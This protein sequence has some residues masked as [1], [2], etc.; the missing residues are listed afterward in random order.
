MSGFFGAGGL[1]TVIQINQEE[2]KAGRAFFTAYDKT[3]ET[4]GAEQELRIRL[5]TG[6][7]KAFHFNV[8]LFNTVL[9]EMKATVDA[10]FSAAGTTLTP[11][12]MLLGS[13]NTPE[14]VIRFDP[15]LS[16]NGTL[17]IPSP[18][19]E[20]GKGVYFSGGGINVCGGF[21]SMPNKE[22]LLSMQNLDLAAQ[23]GASC[24]PFV[25]NSLFILQ[26]NR[27]VHP[28]FLFKC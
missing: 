22:Y 19:S 24:P 18:G 8:C 14:H 13:T 12:N 15:T 4:S 21:V 10:T 28:P 9:I 27:I 11:S 1:Q 7:T 2:I 5:T 26:T 20:S 17:L 3:V 6:A 25:Y 16:T 23:R